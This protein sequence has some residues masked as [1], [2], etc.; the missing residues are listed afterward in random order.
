MSDLLNRYVQQT[1]E[2]AGILYFGP[3]EP[4]GVFITDSE[5]LLTFLSQ[6]KYVSV[7]HIGDV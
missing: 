3:D 4:A 5:K 1:T 6:W 2:F 7:A